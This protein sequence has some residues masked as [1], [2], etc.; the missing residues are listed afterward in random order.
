M[1]F[2]PVSS[3]FEVSV[4]GDSEVE[5]FS[6]V[7]Y[8]LDAKLSDFLCVSLSAVKLSLIV[9]VGDFLGV[10]SSFIESLSDKNAGLFHDNRTSRLKFVVDPS[11]LSFTLN[12]P[13]VD[14]LDPNT[15]GLD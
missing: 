13:T 9:D 5:F 6:C 10:E 11:V 12:K 3:D 8:R 7:S 15:L 1:G 4:E 14:A 2:C